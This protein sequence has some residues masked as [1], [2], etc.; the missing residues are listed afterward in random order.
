MF[1]FRFR[2]LTGS[3]DLF[4]FLEEESVEEHTPVASAS[5][6]SIESAVPSL[7]AAPLVPT[8]TVEPVVPVA[9]PVAQ[10][11]SAEAAAPTVPEG[12][13]REPLSHTVPNFFPF[14]KIEPIASNFKLGVSSLKKVD[15]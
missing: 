7:L 4:E 11:T 13:R 14:G 9:V 8:V 6:A 1:S 10:A 12:G 5:A 15:R 3:E 2:R